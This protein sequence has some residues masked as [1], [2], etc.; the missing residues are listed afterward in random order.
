MEIIYLTLV[1]LS[2]FIVGFSSVFLYGFIKQKNR[3]LE[4]LTKGDKVCWIVGDSI[5]KRGTFMR[6]QDSFAICIM[7]DGT[8]EYV[9]PVLHELKKEK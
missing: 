3:K 5:I 6:W 2:S 1:F 7:N 4:E 9:A 8:V